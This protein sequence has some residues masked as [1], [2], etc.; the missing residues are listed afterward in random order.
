MMIYRIAMT[1][2]GLF[3][4]VNA[5]LALLKPTEVFPTLL[6]IGADTPASDSHILR[7]VGTHTH[8]YNKSGHT[9]RLNTLTHKATFI[10]FV[11]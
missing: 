9:L 1:A 4:F 3:E 11:C 10:S 2:L 5:A 7:N 8:T 6:F